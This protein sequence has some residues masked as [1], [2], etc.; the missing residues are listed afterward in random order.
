MTFAQ[1]RAISFAAIAIASCARDRAHHRDTFV[2]TIA[3]RSLG[4]ST[5]SPGRD[6]DRPVARSL[7]TQEV[8]ATIS[9]PPAGPAPAQ[10]Q[11]QPQP[12]P[13]AAPP[14]DAGSPGVFAPPPPPPPP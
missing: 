1:L 9:R 8:S 14:P 10:P 3:G 5:A 6:P 7:D 13:P 11:P 4:E 12:Q 2:G